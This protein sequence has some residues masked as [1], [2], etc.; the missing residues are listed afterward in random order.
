MISFVDNVREESIFLK[1]PGET[2]DEVLTYVAN[3]LVELGIVKETYIQGLFEREA[4]SPT[5]LDLG[6]EYNFAI[7]HTFPEHTNKIT[8]C[9]VVPENPVM[10]RNM[11]DPDSDVKVSV[12]VP[13]A[14]QKMDDNIQM[15]PVLMDFFA[16]EENLKSL[17]ACE[18][19]AEVMTLLKAGA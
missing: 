8:V 5:G 15:L 16:N 12:I 13:L 9:I 19:P 1:V 10:F 14:L 2:R 4:H 18:T 3:R 17:L 7:P 11:G 6:G